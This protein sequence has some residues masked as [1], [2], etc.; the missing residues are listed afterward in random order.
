MV[1][2]SMPLCYSLSPD[3]LVWQGTNDGVFSVKSAYHMG[4]ESNSRG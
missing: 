2:A 4:M 1:I 3:K